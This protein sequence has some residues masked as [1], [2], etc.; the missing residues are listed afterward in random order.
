MSLRLR[1]EKLAHVVYALTRE[2]VEKTPEK[3]EKVL[4][5]SPIA[6]HDVLSFLV[7]RL[8]NDG[9]ATDEEFAFL[10]D[11]IKTDE[12][13]TLLIESMHK[14]SRTQTVEMVKLTACGMP[15]W[16][17]RAFVKAFLAGKSTVPVSK[18][19]EVAMP[20]TEIPSLAV[21]SSEKINPLEWYKKVRKEVLRLSQEK[22]AKKWGE[23][24]GTQKKGIDVSQFESGRYTYMPQA[25]KELLTVFEIDELDFFADT[26]ENLSYFGQEKEKTLHG[27][28]IGPAR[29]P[30]DQKYT[31]GEWVEQ[32]IN[33]RHL[34]LQDVADAFNQTSGTKYSALDFQHLVDESTDLHTRREVVSGI[35]RIFVLKEDDLVKATGIQLSSLET[36]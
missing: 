7:S 14:A 33:D 23:L 26:G 16:L 30:N 34:S 32:L 19:K 35:L 4:W 24:T 28:S 5:E 3:V 27:E 8:E 21:Q 20:S 18:P 11:R 22:V 25:A 15:S 36:V 9:E 31:V 1:S 6:T 12:Y 10:L 13:E 17:V 29:I 2:G